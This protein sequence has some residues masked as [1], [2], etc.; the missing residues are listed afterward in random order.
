MFSTQS[1][2]QTVRFPW[3][4]RKKHS[5]SSKHEIEIFNANGI[6]KISYQRNKFK[7]IIYFKNIHFF[8]HCIIIN[9]SL[10]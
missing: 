2:F 8:R 3:D 5:Q 7:K 4:Q 1:S 9:I 10:K 6:K